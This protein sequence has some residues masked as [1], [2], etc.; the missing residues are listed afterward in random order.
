MY[1][2]DLPRTIYIVPFS[3]GFWGYPIII[4]DPIVKSCVIT[5]KF[6]IIRF[7]THSKIHKCMSY[8]QLCTFCNLPS[9]A[10]FNPE[11]AKNINPKNPWKNMTVESAGLSFFAV[12]WHNSLQVQQ[13]WQVIKR[14]PVTLLTQNNCGSP[15][16]FVQRSNRYMSWLILWQ[17]SPGPGLVPDRLTFQ[18]GKWE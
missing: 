2:S 12:T 8:A 7:G 17:G 5:N 18:W 4:Q 16:C 9:T 15:G 1:W 3:H 6:A 14:N 11:L 10:R 13:G